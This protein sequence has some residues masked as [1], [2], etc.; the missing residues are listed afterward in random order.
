MKCRWEERA[1]LRH[2]I[3]DWRRANPILHLIQLIVL[4]Y[5][6]DLLLDRREAR[7]LY[8]VVVSLNEEHI[9][10]L[11]SASIPDGPAD[12][13]ECKAMSLIIQPLMDVK[14]TGSCGS[15]FGNVLSN[16]T[17]LRSG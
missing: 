12:P 17:D 16:S 6:S 11:A 9:L 13:A 2:M 14:I 15:A 4:E 3:F 1:P 8:M 10:R 5:G 7:R